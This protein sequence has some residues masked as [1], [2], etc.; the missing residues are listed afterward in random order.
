ML[1]TADKPTA[2]RKADFKL[3]IIASRQ[4]DYD[5]A[6]EHWIPLTNDGAVEHGGRIYLLDRNRGLDVLEMTL[7]AGIRGI[8]WTKRIC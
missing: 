8:S 4:G 1:A 3:G 2:D 7:W 5:K 6:L